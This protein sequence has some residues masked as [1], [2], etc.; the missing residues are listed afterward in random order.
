MAGNACAGY[1]SDRWGR[2]SVLLL[3]AILF[4]ASSLT[5]ALATSFSV[6]IAARIA[7]GLSVEE[8][9]GQ[10]EKSSEDGGA[11]HVACQHLFSF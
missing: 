1:M 4:F 8:R 5:A 7:G 2:R 6:F 3:T 11:K 9:C 10:G